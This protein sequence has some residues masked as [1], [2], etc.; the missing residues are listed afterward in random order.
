[1]KLQEQTIKERLAQ[2]KIDTTKPV[3]ECIMDL[4]QILDNRRKHSG[5]NDG[6]YDGEAMMFDLQIYCNLTEEQATELY[7]EYTNLKKEK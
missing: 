2:L 5:L 1:M 3:K 4:I 6:M 7:K